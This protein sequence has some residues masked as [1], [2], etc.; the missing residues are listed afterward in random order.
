MDGFV[1]SSVVH[2]LNATLTDG[3]LDKIAQPEAD[4][5]VLS[6]RAH[7]AN[8][9]LLL[10]ANANAPRIHFTAQSKQSPLTAPMFTMVLRKH[11]GGGRLL[12]AVQPDFERVVELHF[13]ARDEM[14]DKSVKRL[15][16]EIMGKHSNIILTDEDGIILE[17]IKHISH[18]TSSVREVLPGRRYT[19]PPGGKANPHTTDAA[20]F[21]ALLTREAMQTAKAQP[22]FYQSFNGISPVAASEICARAGISPDTFVSALSCDEREALFASFAK[23]LT[24]AYSNHIYFDQG[25]AVDFTVFPLQI[26][27]G[28]EEKTPDSVCE[29]LES[30]YLKRDNAYRLG[31]KTT[32]LRKHINGHMERC[33][34]KQFVFE[35]TLREVQD[36]D[37]LKTYG[38]LLTAYIYAVPAGAESFDAPD[39]FDPEKTLRIPLDAALTAAENAQAYFKKYNKQKRTFAALQEQMRQNHEELLYLDS[40]SAALQTIAD[41]ADIAEIRAELAQQGLAKAKFKKQAQKARQKSAPLHFVSSDGFDLYVGKNNSQNDELTLRFA[42]GGDIWMHTKD[43]AG[44]HVIIRT[45]NKIPP[46]ATLQEGANLAAYFSKARESGQVPVDYTPKKHVRKP[47]GAKPGFVIYDHHK[48]LYVTP[49][50]PL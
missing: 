10:T 2:T 44:S 14:G 4:E 29:M 40:V 12:C 16:I 18:N 33:R 11:I 20:A 5:V 28:Y 41:E 17:A 15:I 24:L 21:A 49:V 25:R 13:E 48:T 31:Q 19:R 43:I 38:E 30:F 35:K 36:R 23:V 37:Q 3:R 45:N 46:D 39:F 1:I 8:R 6:M 34:K 42:Q 47:N 9:K 26:Y 32:D 27:Q 7:G 22:F 50:A